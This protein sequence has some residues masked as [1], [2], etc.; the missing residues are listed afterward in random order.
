[1]PSTRSKPFFEAVQEGLIEGIR[2]LRGEVE[3][4]TTMFP[5]PPP[6]VT[7]EDLTALRRRADMSQAAF[8]RLLNVST[9][10]VQSWEQGT[11]KPAQATLRLIQVLEQ[12]PRS[13]FE[14][15]GLPAP[16]SSEKAQ[17]R[18]SSGARAKARN[19]PRS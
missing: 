13:V 5:E 9:K 15:A 6:E 10:T 12:D 8:A 11:R 1:M 4:K 16:G 17:R 19:S 18:G 7:P 3:L 2:F 14:A